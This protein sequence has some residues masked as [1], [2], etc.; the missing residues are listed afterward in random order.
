MLQD[1]DGKPKDHS[2]PH[3]GYRQRLLLADSGQFLSSRPILRFQ[4]TQGMDTMCRCAQYPSSMS[5]DQQP[6]PIEHR[7]R[8]DYRDEAEHAEVARILAELPVEH[9]ARIA[10]VTGAREA[11]DS[12]SLSW[13]VADR[14]DMVQALTDANMA[15]YRRMLARKVGYFR[16]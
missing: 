6:I 15:A 16:P 13:L 12:I 11:S 2:P 1:Q 10:Y 8:A 7:H 5:P 9:P 3:T 4:D 14:S